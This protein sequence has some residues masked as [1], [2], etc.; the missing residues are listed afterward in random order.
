MRSLGL[1]LICKKKKMCKRDSTFLDFGFYVYSKDKINSFSF[2]LNRAWFIV[3]MSFTATYIFFQ[4]TMCEIPVREI[5]I[6]SF[7]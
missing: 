6:H 7:I 5:L 4:C 3:L 2:W 1:N